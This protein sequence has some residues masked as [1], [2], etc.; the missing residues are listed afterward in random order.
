M[1]RTHV[2]GLVLAISLLALTATAQAAETKP[3]PAPAGQQ[4][5]TRIE[6]DQKAGIIRFIVNGKEVARLDANGLTVRGNI[7]Y[8]G[9]LTDI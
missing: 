8:T 1:E 2:R 6:T 9:T 7:A 4:P 5:A 3:A